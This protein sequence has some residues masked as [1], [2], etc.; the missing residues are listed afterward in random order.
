MPDYVQLTDDEITHLAEERSELTEE[1]KQQLD[2]ELRRRNITIADVAAYSKE[3]QRLSEAPDPNLFTA[4]VYHPYG[5]GKKLFGKTNHSHDP[6]SDF[7]EFDTTLWVVIFWLP[8]IP[9]SG[10]RVRR[11][12]RRQWKYL[13]ARRIWT[14]RKLPRNWEQILLTWTKAAALLLVAILIVRDLPSL[15]SKLQL[16]RL[17]R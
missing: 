16:Y 5:I 13:F 2:I 8:V 11:D 10:Y 9:L 17:P 14:V 1:A 15:L 6:D 7:E 12:V 4:R 3:S